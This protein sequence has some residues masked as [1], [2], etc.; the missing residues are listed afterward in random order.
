[1]EK[2]IPSEERKKNEIEQSPELI[3]FENVDRRGNLFNPIS[4]SPAPSPLS[5]LQA[6][7]PSTVFA[8]ERMRD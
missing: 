2:E 7:H 5:T 4:G 8:T 6:I 1:M 3:T